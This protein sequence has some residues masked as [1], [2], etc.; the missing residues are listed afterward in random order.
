MISKHA[1]MLEELQIDEDFSFLAISNSIK[2]ELV[3][4]LTNIAKFGNAK[5]QAG[6]FFMLFSESA[7]H[8]IIYAPAKVSIFYTSIQRDQF[9]EYHIEK[10]FTKGGDKDG[11]MLKLNISDWKQ[12]SRYFENYTQFIMYRME[13]GIQ[14]I[15]IAKEPSST[16]KE[17]QIVSTFRFIIPE[18]TL[19]SHSQGIMSPAVFW[20]SMPNSMNIIAVLNFQD[21]LALEEIINSTFSM[22]DDKITLYINE[23]KTFF[24]SNT[25]QEFTQDIDIFDAIKVKFPTGERSDST[26]K[27]LDWSPGIQPTQVNFTYN[28]RHLKAATNLLS[29][30]AIL[31]LKL[32][33]EGQMILIVERNQGIIS[34]AVIPCEVKL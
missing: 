5:D 21:A 13:S 4:S 11:C 33:Q 2:P 26:L 28:I 29:K 10:R 18:L 7:V 31:K 9:D 12:K 27:I 1:K 25:P 17:G 16:S 32:F 15:I 22:K 14:F 30:G 3:D 23:V 6:E 24:F 34:H 19:S 20:D 8:F